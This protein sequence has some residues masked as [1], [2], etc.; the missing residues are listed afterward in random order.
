MKRF[1]SILLVAVVLVSWMP[2]AQPLSVQASQTG[3]QMLGDFRSGTDSSN[4][5]SIMPFGDKLFFTA[6]GPDSQEQPW[7]TDGTQAGTFLLKNISMFTLSM[8]NFGAVSNGMAYF[9][10][11][12][13]ASGEEL[14]K[15]D[16]TPQGT[17]MIADINPGPGGSQ[18]QSFVVNNGLVYF[19][20]SP[21]GSYLNHYLYRTDGSAAGTL[22]IGTVIVG[23]LG[24]QVFQGRVYFIGMS[25]AASLELWRT[26]A[27]G[28]G[29][30]MIKPIMSGTF[31]YHANAEFNQM[32]GKLYFAASDN[33]NASQLWSSDGTASGTQS[34][35]T[36]YSNYAASDLTA[37]NGMLYFSAGD[38]GSDF[39][40]WRSDGTPDGTILVDGAPSIFGNPTAVGNDLYFG[41]Q[42]AAFGAE[43]WKLDG[44]SGAVVMLKDINPGAAS[45]Y[46]W[47]FTALDGVVYFIVR[48]AADS[49]INDLWR[50]QGSAETTSLVKQF[51]RIDQ[52]SNLI[53]VY[54][55]GVWNNRLVINGFDPL[56][57]QELWSS[58]GT[59]AGTQLMLDVNTHPKGSDF[60]GGTFLNGELIFSVAETGAP[61]GLWRSDGT[62]IGSTRLASIPKVDYFKNSYGYSSPTSAV[63]GNFV[64]FTSPTGQN[65]ST[66]I[67]RTDGTP[68]GTEQFTDLTSQ[69]QNTWVTS[70]ASDGNFLYLSMGHYV[71][72]GLWRTNGKP[73]GTLRIGNQP[74]G[75]LATLNQRVI[76]SYEKDSDTQLWRSTASGG[77]EQFATLPY[78]N[79][80]SEYEVHAGQLFFTTGEIYNGASCPVYRTDGETVEEIKA[81]GSSS[82]LNK[83]QG[84]DFVGDTL[85]ISGTHDGVAGLWKLASGANEAVLVQSFSTSPAKLVGGGNRIFFQ[86]PDGSGGGEL[87]VSDGTAP[88]THALCPACAFTQIDWTGGM[89]AWQ[90]LLYFSAAD[91]AHG[92]ELWQSDGTPAGTRL[93]L[94]L[95][96]GPASSNPANLTAQG[97]K[98]FFSAD[99][100]I[101][102]SEP[103]AVVR[104]LDQAVYVPLVKR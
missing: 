91:A 3:P 43:P 22:K 11:I 13:P 27:D 81:A 49:S 71:S 100:G 55:L 99:D 80:I 74:D 66:T 98:L 8:T 28:L 15:T 10:G 26:T 73:G 57:G 69:W 104:V 103:W 78:G 76:F 92:T 17:Q 63:L 18:S 46:A 38:S 36:F 94:D 23:E 65:D 39:R 95:R 51:T 50:T 61:F 53:G 7:I 82:P 20:A 35:R 96:P 1:F 67:W 24:L 77:V 84:L 12:S 37:L 70:M 58:D 40:L 6:E 32:S 34:L 64:Y 30:E 89:L 59:P 54:V 87:W 4:P 5:S 83:I 29:V 62:P 25:S 45:S 21:T 41:G 86:L 2:G 85:Y 88:G 16:G 44:T 48:D 101:H 19:A 56:H 60:Q 31:S 93:S 102:G 79:R 97:D 47:G 90:G 9:A 72:T 68:A 14:W 42:N 52:Q 33:S 75:T